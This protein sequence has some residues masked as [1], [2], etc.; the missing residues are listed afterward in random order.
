VDELHED[1]I[2][3]PLQVENSTAMLLTCPIIVIYMSNSSW[4]SSSSFLSGFELSR[5]DERAELTET[6]EFDVVGDMYRHPLAQS[7][8]GGGRYRKSYDIYSLGVVLVEIAL[9]KRIEDVVGFDDLRS[10]RP[11]QLKRLQAW[12]LGDTAEPVAGM[13][14]TLKD[15]PCL[16]SVAAECGDIFQDTVGLCLTTDGVESPLFRGE[17][18]HTVSGK[19]QKLVTDEIVNRLE[20]MAN[21]LQR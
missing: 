2:L 17:S 13:P 1:Q 16:E 7:S 8:E 9:W 5:P 10:V 6:P 21:V 3:I 15:R 18:E 19:L 20:Q 14:T 11:P 12:L 4:S